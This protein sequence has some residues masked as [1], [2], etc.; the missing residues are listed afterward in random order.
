MTGLK[1]YRR[2]DE[3]FK[4]PQEKGKLKTRKAE[5]GRDKEMKGTLR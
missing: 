4:S 1:K 5:V 2:R 3:F